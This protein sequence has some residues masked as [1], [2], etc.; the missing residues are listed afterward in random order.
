MLTLEELCEEIECIEGKQPTWDLCNKLASL[1][2]IKDHMP[3]GKVGTMP[4][5]YESG[6]STVTSPS[7][8]K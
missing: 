6:P 2:I 8:M 1:Y 5:N 4:M 7:M 3:K